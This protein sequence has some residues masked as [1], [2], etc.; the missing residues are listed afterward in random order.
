MLRIIRRVCGR[1]VSVMPGGKPQQRDEGTMKQHR[2]GFIFFRMMLAAAVIM[3]AGLQGCGGGGGGSAAGPALNI[4]SGHGRVAADVRFEIPPGSARYAAASGDAIHITVTISGYYGEDP[5]LPFK[6]I[7]EETDVD[8]DTG[9]AAMTLLD[10]P[11]GINHLLTAEAVFPEGPSL[12]VKG[13]IEEL[14]EGERVTVTVNSRSTVVADAAI[15]LAEQENTILP[16]ITLTQLRTI[17]AA[18]DAIY[19]G[20]T[21]YESIDIDN[22]LA[23]SA[24]ADVPDSITVSPDTTDV[25]VNASAQFTATVKNKYNV[26]IS[27]AQVDWSLS[28]EIG[29]ID[30]TGLFTASA[31]GQGVVT[32]ACGDL[33]TTAAVTVVELGQVVAVAVS[34][35]LTPYVTVGDTIPFTL[36][37]EDVNGNTA[38][39]SSLADWT[40]SAG[41]TNRTGS[42]FVAASSGTQSVTGSYQGVDD[43]LEFNVEPAWPQV[44][45]PAAAAP[46]TFGEAYSGVFSA[47]G[48]TPPMT[49]SIGMGALPPGMS[50]DSGTQIISGT[51]PDYVSR[52]EVYV[53]VADSLGRAT[54]YDGPYYSGAFG[55]TLNVD[56]QLQEFESKLQTADSA[57]SE[58][59]DLL[60]NARSVAVSEAGM[61]NTANQSQYEAIMGQIDSIVS[62]A[63]YGSDNLVDGTFAA[64]PIQVALS[65]GASP[66]YLEANIPD[67]ST[68][69]LGLDVSSVETTQDATNAIT[70]LDTAI[71]TTSSTRASLGAS[72]NAAQL[73]EGI[74]DSLVLY[75]PTAVCIQ[76]LYNFTTTS[77]AVLTEISN[78]LQQ[79]QNMAVQ[80]QGGGVTT[81]QKQLLQN[82]AE[83]YLDALDKITTTAT[84]NS[85]LLVDG[86]LSQTCTDAPVVSVAGMA[87]SSLGISGINLVSAPTLAQ[88]YIESAMATVNG[89]R[90][91][92]SSQQTTISGML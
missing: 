32:A 12:T 55:F 17:E 50:F 2:R 9:V 22:V 52:W 49:W 34:A 16:E 38:D 45:T 57:L 26:T 42:E 77:D 8:P 91:T 84:F 35:T 70:L 60:Q 68:P 73:F 24:D 72:N 23:Y 59:S 66:V 69:S 21:P 30:D 46:S 53:D 51:A 47:V 6:P 80:A 37:A 25:A 56:S 90:S 14:P 63:S 7:T 64:N 65:G 89:E 67:H 78:L 44:Q 79:M 43:T 85:T 18:V 48:G 61:H 82:E 4:P 15:A 87:A 31:V 58:I 28:G 19:S 5:P 74:F 3:L 29:S 36:T 13:L 33:S 76:D 62:T 75:A 88:A 83:I 92:L 10:V 41:L 71:E 81:A 40:G 1:S 54:S 39:V 86:T 27:E 20:G 11:V